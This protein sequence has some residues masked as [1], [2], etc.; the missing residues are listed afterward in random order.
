MVSGNQDY[1]NPTICQALQLM[2]KDLTSRWVNGI[3]KAARRA[4]AKFCEF[5]VSCPN[6]VN[7]GRQV[8]YSGDM[9]AGQMIAGLVNMEH[10]NRV[11]AEA[12]T[13]T[14]LEQK[15]Q[16]FVSLE[17]TDMSIPY[18]HK[19]MHSLTLSNVQRSYHKQWSPETKT[20]STPWYAKHCSWCGKISHPGG[21][22]DREKLPGGRAG[23]PLLWGEGSHK[24]GMLEAPWHPEWTPRSKASRSEE[25]F[26]F[27][28]K[29]H[30]ARKHNRM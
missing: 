21:S 8:N 10:Q 27:A 1:F 29:N 6:K 5:T 15:I 24:K 26:V 4:Q 2:W 7:C 19:T 9:V 3:A 13:L 12:A 14:T 18:L 17:T 25:S 16:R 30:A 23:M 11:L 28:N 20:T 22:M